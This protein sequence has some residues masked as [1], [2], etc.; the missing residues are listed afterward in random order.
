MRHLFLLVALAWLI[1]TAAWAQTTVGP[2]NAIVCN[3]EAQ[4][5]AGP[6]TIQQLVAPKANTRIYICGWHVTN[7]AAAGTYQI[8]YGTQT[9]NPCDTAN[10]NF[11]PAMN[12]SSSAP[13][14]DHIDY[15]IN[16]SN[17][18]SGLCFTPSVATIAAIIYFAQY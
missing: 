10:G 12:V 7:T 2:P 11:T 14:T 9:T 15:V 8:T 17:V 4:M 3:A 13:A 16:Q 18:G 1:G 5:A 6:T